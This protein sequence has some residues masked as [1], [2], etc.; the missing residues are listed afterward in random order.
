[1]KIYL[2]ENKH[3]YDLD[4]HQNECDDFE[5]S[6]AAPPL[7]A[8]LL[9]GTNDKR[10]R[11]RMTPKVPQFRFDGRKL[12]MPLADALRFSLEKKHIESGQK[13][14][15]IISGFRITYRNWVRITNGDVIPSFSTLLQIKRYLNDDYL[16]DLIDSAYIASASKK[17]RFTREDIESIIGHFSG[18]KC[19][20]R[21]LDEPLNFRKICYSENIKFSDADESINAINYFI[22]IRTMIISRRIKSLNAED[23]YFRILITLYREN[24]IYR[25]GNDYINQNE[26][27]SQ[28]DQL[29]LHN[30]SSFFLGSIVDQRILMIFNPEEVFFPDE[31]RDF[32]E[33]VI[34]NLDYVHDLYSIFDSD[35]SDPL[36]A[37]GFK[38]A[39]TDAYLNKLR[40]MSIHS[41]DLAGKALPLILELNKK[42]IDEGADRWLTIYNDIAIIDAYISLRKFDDALHLVEKIE[43]EGGNVIARHLGEINLIKAK[44]FDRI[45]ERENFE[46]TIDCAKKHYTEMGNAGKIGI[47]E[48]I[49]AFSKGR[50]V[51][52]S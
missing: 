26:S 18:I 36:R 32:L 1:M 39:S 33:D 47:I 35:D 6:H 24:L 41:F 11:H 16:S 5:F 38:N 4:N 50:K 13:K 27:I 29:H 7:C 20:L 22:F 15:E 44:I 9:Q 10:K 28:M 21:D 31:N 43:V 34:T 52:G 23:V 8:D 40:A 12:E 2:L 49:L 42:D 25:Y 51:I 3:Q 48:K 45:G 30:K 37:Y 17:E 19:E 14:M 46:H